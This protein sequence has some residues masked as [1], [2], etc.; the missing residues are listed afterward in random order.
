MTVDQ[1][2]NQHT[3]PAPQASSPKPNDQGSVSITGF[4]R[5]SDPQTKE[6]IVEIRA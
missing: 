2:K 5:I 1:P 4:V 6:T 3:A